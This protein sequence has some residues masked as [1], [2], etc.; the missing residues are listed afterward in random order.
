MECVHDQNCSIHIGDGAVQLADDIP[1]R[2]E[3]RN[4]IILCEEQA[5]EL[6]LPTLGDRCPNLRKQPLYYLDAREQNKQISSLLP[7][8]Q[9]WEADGIDRNT[10]VIN[11]GGG[12]LCDM[13]GFAAS[14]FKRGIPFVNIPTTL[15]AMADASVGGKTAVNLD[16][17]KNVIGTFCRPEAVLIDPVFLGTLPEREFLSGMAELIKMQWIANPDFNIDQAE[18]SFSSRPMLSA[19]LHFAIEQKARITALDFKEGNIR[20]T[21]NFGHTFG[22]AFEALALK[23]QQRLTHG[24]AVAHGMVCELYLSW[25]MTGFERETFEICSAWLRKHYG[26]F[27]FSRQEI[28]EL[29]AYMKA[30]KKNI[31]GRVY[32]IL[33]SAFGQCRFTQAVPESLLEKALSAYPFF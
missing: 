13:G 29:I 20:K 14:V 11:I 30:D 8:W 22:H 2:Q 24:E 17:T 33:L 28:P 18:E 16:E 5:A 23:R 32:P 15:L 7:L 9:A 27:Q 26:I 1:L 21:L 6:I 19:L 4:C 3:N 25:L 10:L 12:V 31:E